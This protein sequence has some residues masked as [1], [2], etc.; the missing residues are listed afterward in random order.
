M[1]KSTLQNLVSKPGEQSLLAAQLRKRGH[2][3]SQGHIWN[4][5]HMNSAQNCPPPGYV[6]PICEVFEWAITPHELRED[7]YPNP[8]DGLPPEIAMQKVPGLVLPQAA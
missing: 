7:L 1:N 3:V 4:W 8:W 2:R 5:L 6:L